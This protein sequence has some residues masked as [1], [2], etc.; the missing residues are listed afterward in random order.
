MKTTLKLLLPYEK[1][2][3]DVIEIQPGTA[4]LN[5]SGTGNEK[6]DMSGNN[7]DDDYFD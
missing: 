4:L 2:K 5:V 6:F 1:P 3:T 7:Y